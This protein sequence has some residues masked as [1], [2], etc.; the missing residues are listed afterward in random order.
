MSGLSQDLNV[1]Y[2]R[3]LRM[4][5]AILALWIAAVQTEILSWE[6]VGGSGQK[7][8]SKCIS[9]RQPH[10]VVSGSSV[11]AYCPSFVSHLGFI[12]NMSK[13]RFRIKYFFCDCECIVD[14]NQNSWC[15]EQQMPATQTHWKIIFFKIMLHC[16]LFRDTLKVKCSVSGAKST[17]RFIQ[18]ILI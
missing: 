15:A 9:I 14:G 6:N 17:F 18:N 11:V 13:V 5:N 8:L 10:R 1:K 12:W 2:M 16:C 3:K 4:N 7:L